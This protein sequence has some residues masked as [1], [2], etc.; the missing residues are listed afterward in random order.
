MV[1]QAGGP[2]SNTNEKRARPALALPL[3]TAQQGACG[4]Q[5]RACGGMD[6]KMCGTCP[7]PPSL[8]VFLS[9]R[10]P[11]DSQIGLST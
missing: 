1:A 11:R 2:S 3:V 5:D 6:P 7:K 9:R 8:D 10:D 4:R